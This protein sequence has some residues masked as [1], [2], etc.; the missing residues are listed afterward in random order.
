M[1][2]AAQH[3][4]GNC[5]RPFSSTPLYSRDVSYCCEAC[6]SRHLCTCLTEV[7]LASDGVEGLG[8]PFGS[9]I[10]DETLAGSA[11]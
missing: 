8:L 1:Y 6:L 4:C 9:A 11:R 3:V 2:G 7:D 5:F 10:R